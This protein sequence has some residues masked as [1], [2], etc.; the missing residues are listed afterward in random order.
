MT[1]TEEEEALEFLKDPL[2]FDRILS[3]FEAIGMTGEDGNKLMGY[4]AATS[5]KL[6]EPLSVLIQSGSAAGKSTLQDAVIML[7][8]PEDY[9]KY[10]RLTGQALLQ[11]EENSL[12]HKLLAIEEE[13]GAKDASYSIRNIQSSRVFFR[14]GPQAKTLPPAN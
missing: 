10:T 4:I 2:L 6:D 1:Q 9:I 3:D 12:V 11:K 13:H 8:P 7:I 5:R 14:S